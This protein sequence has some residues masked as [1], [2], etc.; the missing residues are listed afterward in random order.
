[1]KKIDYRQLQPGD[2]L[3]TTSLAAESWSIRAGTKSD[4]SHAMLYVS[5][6][7]VIDSTGDGVHARNLQKMFYD[8]KCAIHSLRPKNPLT[9]DQLSKVIAYAR[10]VTGTGY[11]VIEAVR[12]L[13]NP[14]GNGSDKQFCSR[15]VA[16]AYAAA[17]IALVDNPD[18]CTPQQL[19][20]SPFL[21]LLPS[22]AAS[23][24]DEE[25]RSFT[26]QPNGVEGMVRVTNDFLG[27]VRTL[28][29]KIQSINDALQY[30]IDNPGTDEFVLEALRSS[31][32]LDYWRTELVR[33]PWRHDLNLLTVFVEKN[34]AEVEIHEYCEE[35]LAHDAAGS[36][37]HWEINLATAR[38]RADQFPLKSFAAMARLY[39]NVVGSH[40]VRIHVAQEWLASRAK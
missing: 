12:T 11:S 7:S 15:L 16:R 38:A 2:I 5:S 25:Y 3:L 14:R 35:I 32:Y 13:K 37:K 30:L 27:R 4:I 34:Q 10:A 26:M 28:S 21:S 31:G 36:F 39:E 33:F 19:K 1:M 20:E 24:S 40:Q 6:T 17:G 29:P 8:D 22:P 9:V 23:V 18:F